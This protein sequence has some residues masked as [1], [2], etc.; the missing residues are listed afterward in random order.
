MNR[1]IFLLSV[2]L[3]LSCLLV[4]HR[5]SE[6]EFVNF[7]DDR[8]IVDNPIVVRGLTLEGVKWAFMST[9]AA[10]WHPLTWISHM[11]DCSLFGLDAG[12]HHQVNVFIHCANSVVLFLV[13]VAMTGL[14]WRSAVVAAL[15][16]VHP[17]H[18]ESVAW[19]AERKDLLSTFFWFSTL[20]AYNHYVHFR[21]ARRYLLVFCLYALG[22]LSKPMPVSLPFIL[23]LLDYWPLG[24]L[25]RCGRTY[26]EGVKKAR[27]CGSLEVRSTDVFRQVLLE[28][29][30]LF[31][32]AAGSC[33]ITVIAQRRGGAVV[34]MDTYPLGVRLA[35]AAVSYV[36]YVIKTFWPL[37]L[38]CFYPHPGASLPIW[39]VIGSLTALV[40]ITVFAVIKANRA[41]YIAVSWFWYLVTLLPVI[42]LVQ[43][44]RQASADRYTYVPLVGIFV[45]IVWWVT[46]VV[47]RDRRLVLASGVMASLVLV[48]FA[49]LSYRQ[50]TYWRDSISLFAR[51]A[52]VT[53]NNGLAYYNLGCA[54][55]QAGDV[56]KAR[57]C[58]RKALDLLPGDALHYNSYGCDLLEQGI[59]DMAIV[60]FE[61]AVHADPH[62]D[63]AYVN[64]ATAYIRAGERL[65]AVRV[66]RRALHEN[67]RN[68]DAKEYLRRIERDDVVR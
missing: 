44:G 30:P 12:R 35:N 21:N 32:L 55:F 24:R 62:F 20:L 10:N 61:K 41:P 48:V 23:L 60:A 42:G 34:S 14:P 13:L 53:K 47:K 66:L 4:Y 28:K 1:S 65:E 64:L 38:A 31:L 7:D 67:P 18:V 37:N 16:A 68:T 33:V 51:A 2:L 15:F 58:I 39:Q 43:V 6:F 29:V 17:L 57:E 36:S 3:V 45:G 49:G 63:L 46:E 19:V 25:R 52:A 27:K 22:L 8:Y 26:L 11:L 59:V 40:L 56:V 54:L 50:T 5:A 9:Y